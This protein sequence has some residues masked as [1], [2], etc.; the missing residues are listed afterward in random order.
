MVEIFEV[1]LKGNEGSTVKEILEFSQHKTIQDDDNYFIEFKLT[2]KYQND[3]IT[4]HEWV[5]KF[6]RCVEHS[7]FDEDTI[8]WRRIK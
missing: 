1:N 8:Y 3:Y 2:V 6:Y 7:C 4:T 5:E